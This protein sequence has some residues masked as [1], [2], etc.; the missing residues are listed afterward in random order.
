MRSQAM[1]L[2]VVVVAFLSGCASLPKD[3]DEVGGTTSAKAQTEGYVMLKSFL[4]DER[5][6]K[7]IFFLQDASKP[8]ESLVNHIS[9]RTQKAFDELSAL[10]TLSPSVNLEA[11][12]GLPEAET[13]TREAIAATSTEELLEFEGKPFEKVM[14]LTQTEGLLYGYHL[15]EVLAENEPNTKRRKWLTTLAADL[16]KLHTRVVAKLKVG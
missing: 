5:R 8:I 2:A 16:K 4:N 6:L 7:Q 13:K 1:L 9:E 14:L 11:K 10:A 3:R 15:C 12:D